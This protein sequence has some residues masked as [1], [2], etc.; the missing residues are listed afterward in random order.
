MEMTIRPMLP[1]ERKYTYAQS[2]Q[3]TGQTGSIGRLRGDFGSN[4]EEFYSS[5]DDHSEKLKTQAFKDELDAVINALRSDEKYGGMLASRGKMSAYCHQS[6]ESGFD[7]SYTRE[8]GFRVDT[9]N[10]SYLIRLNPTK[11]DYN[12]YVFCYKRDWLDSHLQ[13]AAKGIRFIDPHYKERFRIADGDRVRIIGKDGENRDRTARYIDDYHV[14]LNSGSVSN[15]FHICEFAERLEASGGTV[16]P[17]RSSLPEQCYSLLDSTG[18]VIILQKG[19]KGY[20]TTDIP[21]TDRTSARQMVDHYNE[22][23]GVNKAQEAAMKA[24]SMFGWD[25]PAADPCRYTI[26]G[27]PFPVKG[28]KHDALSQSYDSMEIFGQP[29]MYFLGRIERSTVPEGMYMYEIRHSDNAEHL[30]VQLGKS[31]LVNH[32]GTIISS[33]PI[34][35]PPDG[36]REIAY[37]DW[38]FTDEGI[39]NLAE[40][41]RKYPPTGEPPNKNRKNEAR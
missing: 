36:L 9:E 3:I 8:Y 1:S 32:Y 26:E 38:G 20:S 25:V 40:Y 34:D 33:K 30:P 15:L 4:G 19:E 18:E 29:V 41:A 21:V 22:K 11:G 37:E 5:W 23:L 13:N 12:F 39:N 10:H 27:I 35:L 6:P 14:E 16:I 7:G 2:Q 31:I 17:L 28:N 24:G